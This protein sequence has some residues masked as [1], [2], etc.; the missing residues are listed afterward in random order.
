MSR[1]NPVN[2]TTI[3][4]C[5]QS[6]QI[7]TCASIHR[8]SLLVFAE[9]KEDLEKQFL[10]TYT[11]KPIQ[12]AWNREGNTLCQREFEFE[13]LMITEVNDTVSQTSECKIGTSAEE[14][15][16]SRDESESRA[17]D[18][19]RSVSQADSSGCSSE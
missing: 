8:Y 3:A 6:Y 16:P 13:L 11:V 10:R 2:L 1:L 7:A 19:S 9:Q 5:C 15:P 17:H 18:T 14:L 4:D 12:D